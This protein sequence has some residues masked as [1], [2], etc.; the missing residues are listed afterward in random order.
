MFLLFL[1]MQCKRWHSKSVWLSRCCT[2]DVIE[3]HLRH[4]HECTSKVVESSQDTLLW[5]QG[6]NHTHVAGSALV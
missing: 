3:R 5:K 4:A 1:T 6:A 2:L